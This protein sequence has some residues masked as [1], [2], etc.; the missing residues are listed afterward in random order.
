[1]LAVT[2]AIGLQ[3][4]R[5][6]QRSFCMDIDIQSAKLGT[7][8]PCAGTFQGPGVQDPGNLQQQHLK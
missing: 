5:A 6:K 1:M 2:L 4:T 7:C 3:L 8:V